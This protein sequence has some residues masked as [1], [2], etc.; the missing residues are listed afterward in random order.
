VATE[1]SGSGDPKRSLELLWG[2]QERPKRG[3]KPRL[4]VDKIA[5]TAIEVADAEGLGA[6]S[7]RRVAEQLGV[8]AMSLYTYIPGK[9]EL[10][11]VMLDTVA[12]EAPLLDTLGGDWRARVE[13]WAREG[14]AALRRHPWVLQVGTSHPPMGP[15]EVA[16]TDSALRALSGT[17]LTEHE[18]VAVINVVNGYLRGVAGTLVDAVQVEQHTGVT[19][20]QWYA[21]HAPLLDQLIQPSRFPTITSFH[22]AGVFENPIDHFEFG[23]Q[24]L[25]DGIEAFIRGR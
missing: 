1:Y 8:S 11:D 16:W 4:T 12:G 24:R 15:S 3:P 2:I 13:Q 20:E 10:I 14:L 5:T 7:M 25:L 19:D 17:G 22:T 18:I 21:E 9:A 23:L 6:L